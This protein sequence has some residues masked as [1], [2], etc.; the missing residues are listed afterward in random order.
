MRKD[1]KLALDWGIT[2]AAIPEEGRHRNSGPKGLDVLALRL[3]LSMK[4]PSDSAW[5]QVWTRF[6]SSRKRGVSTTGCF[7]NYRE[8]VLHSKPFGCRR[9]LG[10]M[11]NPQAPEHP[12]TQVG[13]QQKA[14]VKP[15]GKN[16]RK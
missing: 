16:R 8:F 5:L 12:E 10:M 13:L 1:P 15:L 11:A 7:L 3:F 14:C 6:G 9:I 4:G 2:K